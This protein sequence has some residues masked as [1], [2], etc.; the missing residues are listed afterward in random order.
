MDISNPEFWQERYSSDNTPWD[1]ETTTPS[2]INSITYSDQLNQVLRPRDMSLSNI[3]LLETLGR[4]IPNIVNQLTTLKR[5]EK[6][7]GLRIRK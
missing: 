7:R 6:Y 3:K 4:K 5:Q 1:T 2:L